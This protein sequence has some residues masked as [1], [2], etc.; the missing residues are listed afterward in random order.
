MYYETGLRD[1]STWLLSSDSHPLRDVLLTIQP[2]HMG[3]LFACSS[4]HGGEAN[5]ALRGYSLRV[6]NLSPQPVEF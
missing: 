4:Y 5:L 6:D 2:L 3:L 1:V